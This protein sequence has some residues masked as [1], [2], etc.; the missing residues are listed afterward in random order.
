MFSGV[1]TA[2][3]VSVEIRVEARKPEWSDTA[4]ADSSFVLAAR[5]LVYTVMNDSNLI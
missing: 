5:L 4:P 3:A 2:A 1:F